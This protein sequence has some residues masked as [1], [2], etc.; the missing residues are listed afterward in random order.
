MSFRSKQTGWQIILAGLFLLLMTSSAFAQ[1]PPTCSGCGKTIVGSYVE[2]E[3]KAYHKA[4]VVCAECGKR[5]LGQYG[6]KDG[7]LYHPDCYEQAHAPRCGVCGEPIVGQY[8]TL[9]G[10]AYHQ[11]CYRDRVAKRCVVCGEVIQGQYIEDGWG[12]T[13]HARHHETVPR[14]DSCSRFLAGLSGTRHL[15]DG[16]SLCADCWRGGVHDLPHAERLMGE[17]QRI[18]GEAGIG[19]LTPL[20]TISL[21]L[22]DKQKIATIGGVGGDTYGVHEVESK[23]TSDGRVILEE[24]TIYLVRDLPEEQALAVL[25]HELFHVWQHERGAD[26]GAAQWREGSANVAGWLA[27][28]SR[29]TELARFLLEKMDEAPDL[30]YGT[31]FRRA[32]RL[33]ETRGK[34]VFLERVLLEGKR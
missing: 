13:I 9:E 5:I 25:A 27:L 33:Y 3:G 22:V 18:L 11:D 21:E 12:G 26:G 14:C 28:Q 6:S 20:E 23:R 19:L 2:I 17:A 10:Q 29:N 8:V 15:D 30:T 7:N 31:G 24:T 16:R 32:K 4:C 1:Q 34:V